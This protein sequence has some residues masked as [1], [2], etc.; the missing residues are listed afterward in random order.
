MEKKYKISNKIYPDD[1]IEQ[2][3]SDFKEV[4]YI[5][6]HSWE[7]TIRWDDEGSIDE[8]FNEFMNYVIWLIN[9]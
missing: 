4:W 5:A 2:S 8:I 7:L 3:V 9:E 1:V 6:F